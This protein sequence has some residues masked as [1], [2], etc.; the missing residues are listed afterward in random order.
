MDKKSIFCVLMTAFC[1]GTMEVA[2]KLGGLS[3][4]SIQIV[5]LRFAIGGILLLPF[6]IA[7]LRRRKCR[8]TGADIAYLF[9]LG[10]VCIGSMALM[11]IGLGSINAN[12]ASI[13]ISMNPLFTMIFARFVVGEIFTRRKA[14]VLLL[15]FIGLIIVINPKNLVSGNLNV[16]GLLITLLS[17]VAFGLYTALGK[18][19]LEKIGGMAQNC[20]TFLFGDVVLLIAMLYTGIPIVEGITLQ[21]LPVMLYLGIVVTAAGYFF[22]VKAIALSG[23]SNASIAFF[24]KPVLAPIV[25]LI[26]LKEAITI[27]FIIGVVFILVGSYIKMIPEKE[28]SAKEAVTHVHA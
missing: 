12:V 1:F 28:Q 16:T 10:V 9:I 19:R 22:F 27:N 2:S 15:S 6:A 25:A 11:Q 24:I 4:N 13:I 7:D 20:L 8:L 14:L 21:S 23:P 17:A 18:K 3:F 26:V 5:F